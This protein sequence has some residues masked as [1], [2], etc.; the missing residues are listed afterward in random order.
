MEC[1]SY[2]KQEGLLLFMRCH[3][4]RKSPLGD[5]HGWQPKIFWQDVPEASAKD[6]AGMTKLSFFGMESRC[7]FIFSHVVFDDDLSGFWILSTFHDHK[8]SGTG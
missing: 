3:L 5:C 7:S 6:V 4:H 2:P 8:F 1:T